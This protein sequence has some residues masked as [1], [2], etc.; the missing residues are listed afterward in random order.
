M[1]LKY[2]KG[3]SLIEVVIASGI[4]ATAIVFIL[5]GF[6]QSLMAVRISENITLASFLA[7]E[8][9]FDIEQKVK[10]GAAMQNFSGQETSQ[11]RSFKWDFSL[12]ENDA[13]LKELDLAV[14]WLDSARGEQAVNF[15]SLL[16]S[17]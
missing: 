3:F 16:I 17:K 8:E 11:G 7:Q 15:K 13:G 12:L 14:S 4:A 10:N 6:T 9:I 5:R 1:R 2:N